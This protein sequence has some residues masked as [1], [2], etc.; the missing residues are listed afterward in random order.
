MKLSS[1]EHHYYQYLICW[2]Q[3]PSEISFLIIFKRINRRTDSGKER[4]QNKSIVGEW[5][6]RPVF[7]LSCNW[8][9][10]WNSICLSKNKSFEKREEQ[11]LYDF[12]SFIS[13]FFCFCYKFLLINSLISHWLR[14]NTS[15]WFLAT[16]LSICSQEKASIEIRNDSK[17]LRNRNF[18]AMLQISKFSFNVSLFPSQFFKHL[19]NS[20]PFFDNLPEKNEAK[21]DEQIM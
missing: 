4:R 9:L 11:K 13:L 10:V 6:S 19:S 3:K 12:D 8:Y 16:R 14:Q 7:F 2:Y 21:K 15:C 1:I 17:A 18:V 5:L 20:F